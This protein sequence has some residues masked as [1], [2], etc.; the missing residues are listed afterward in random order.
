MTDQVKNLELKNYRQ[1]A[2]INSDI[3]PILKDQIVEK[4]AAGELD[5]L[6]I[7]PETLIYENDFDND[8]IWDLLE[9]YFLGK[10]PAEVQFSP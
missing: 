6:Y 8:K 2:T 10:I 5:I 4:V 9:D 1:A 7:S 3:S